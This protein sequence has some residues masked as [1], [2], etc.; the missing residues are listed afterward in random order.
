MYLA[1]TCDVPRALSR[2]FR[3]LALIFQGCWWLPLAV[4]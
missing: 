1:W 3:P 4:V 2:R